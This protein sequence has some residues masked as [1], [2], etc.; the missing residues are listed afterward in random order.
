MKF[1]N[2]YNYTSIL[3]YW[4]ICI[5]SS[6]NECIFQL[7]LVV[8]IQKLFIKMSETADAECMD[9]YTVDV[10]KNYFFRLIIHKYYNFKAS[11]FHLSL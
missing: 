11:V 3:I 2:I 10:L 1:S 9:V 8:Q 7:L 5:H 4:I 6:L